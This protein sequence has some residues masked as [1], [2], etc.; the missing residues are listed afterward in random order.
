M[1]PGRMVWLASY[2]KSGNTNVRGFI[3][4]YRLGGDSIDINDLD[5]GHAAWR[6]VLDELLGL[7]T[8][9]LL[10]SELR[11]LLPKAYCQWSQQAKQTTFL[12]TYDCWILTPKGEPLFPPEATQ[13]LIHIVRDPLDVAVSVGYHRGVEMDTAIDRMNASDYWAALEA[14]NPQIPQ[15]LSDW[16]NHAQSWK[17]SNMPSLLL[18]YEDLRL[19]PVACFRQVLGFVG[20]E[21]NES[22]LERAVQACSFER[23]QAQE[24]AGGFRERLA[25]AKAGFFRQGQVG[26]WRA[27]LSAQ[28]VQ[29]IVDSH[30]PVMRE[31]GYLESFD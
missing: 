8:A 7:S 28:Q 31:L 2:P 24:Q 30:A 6:P 23:L 9:D 19:D 5:A 15:F 12:K 16:S 26:F 27:V 1:R 13:G 11:N 3:T 29:R 14:D 25:S 17:R 22:K 18:R 20:W 21:V 10:H 4:A